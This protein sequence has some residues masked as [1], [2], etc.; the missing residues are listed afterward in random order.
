MGQRGG[1]LTVG[2]RRQGCDVGPPYEM[3]RKDEC[4]SDKYMVKLQCSS[5][6]CRSLIVV[7]LRKLQQRAGFTRYAHHESAVPNAPIHI[8]PVGRF[9]V[10]KGRVATA[11]TAA[12]L[13]RNSSSGP[14]G[15][16]QDWPIPRPILRWTRNPAGRCRTRSL[17]MYPTKVVQI[18]THLSTSICAERTTTSAS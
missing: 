2:T 4:Q 18:C 6:A 12:A 14:C 17:N 15:M 8:H 11:N 9:C 7:A 13:I 3:G 5:G 10:E 16:E 1:D